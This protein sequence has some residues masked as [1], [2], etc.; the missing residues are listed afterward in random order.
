MIS[1]LKQFIRNSSE[2]NPFPNESVCSLQVSELAKGAK[3]SSK[4]S[5]LNKQMSRKSL[6]KCKNTV[7]S[8]FCS[9]EEENASVKCMPNKY[10]AYKNNALKSE[11]R[12][13]LNRSMVGRP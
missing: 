9:S 11:S 1:E 4:I 8:D 2:K 13:A 5:L 12:R 3:K 7:I 6:Q 10:S